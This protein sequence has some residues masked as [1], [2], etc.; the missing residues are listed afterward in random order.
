MNKNSEAMPR[1]FARQRCANL[2]AGVRS[3]LG[4]TS[5]RFR[6]RL[7]NGIFAAGIV[8]FIVI[9]HQALQVQLNATVDFLSG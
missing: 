4:N 9:T 3:V 1:A 8:S 7:I 6:M 2:R 5:L